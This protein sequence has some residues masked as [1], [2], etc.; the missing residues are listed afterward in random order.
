MEKKLLDCEWIILQAL[1]GRGPQSMGEIIASVKRDHPEIGWKYKT[2]HSYLRVMLE[3]ELIGC[4][5]LTVKEKRYFALLSQEQALEQESESL[6]ARVSS[7]SLG[8]MMAMMAQKADLSE[9]DKEEFAAL[10]AR[11]DKPEGGRS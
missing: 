10:F 6:L 9:A 8:R 2:Y 1:W 7:R 4:D 3:K 5:V 11:L